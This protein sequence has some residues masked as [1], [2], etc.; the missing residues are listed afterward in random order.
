[1]FHVVGVIDF[2]WPDVTFSC[3]TLVNAKSNKD[4]Q[5]HRRAVEKQQLSCLLLNNRGG[6]GLVP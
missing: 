5:H 1:M 6:T 2:I 4:G 3:Y